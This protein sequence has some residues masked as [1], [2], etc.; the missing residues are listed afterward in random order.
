MSAASW[1]PALFRS[2]F[3][4]STSTSS[5]SVS[6]T[7]IVSS[8]NW[9]SGTALGS[10]LLPRRSGCTHGGA[11]SRT[12]TRVPLSLYR[13][14]IVYECIAA[15]VDE[16]TAVIANGTNPSTDVVFITAPSGC[17]F[18]CSIKAPVIRIGPMRFVVSVETKSCSS[19]ADDAS[20]TFMI[21]ALLINTLSF[22]YS[23]VSFVA[24]AEMLAG[25]SIFNSAHAI[26]GFALATS[27]RRPLRRPAIITWFLRWCSASAKPR[28]IPEPP[29]VMRMVFPESFIE[30]CPCVD[31][32]ATSRTLDKILRTYVLDCQEPAAYTCSVGDLDFQSGHVY[33]LI[34]DN[35]S[36]ELLV[37]AASQTSRS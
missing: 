23:A 28:P 25:S 17:R 16:Y 32:G 37:W 18:R 1:G 8:M 6:R 29:P 21:P 9:A 27:A 3:A 24:T 14:D 13:R 26:P 2:G 11:N 33:C 36:G 31:G 15:L 12:L 19:I 22:G 35:C 30:T 34:T 20:S 7:R 5:A 10:L 4:L